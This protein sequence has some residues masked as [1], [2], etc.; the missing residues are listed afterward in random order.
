MRRAIA[1]VWSAVRKVSVLVI[2]AKPIVGLTDSA[3]MRHMADSVRERALA[4]SSRRIWSGLVVLVILL[5][6][7][8][9][10]DGGE[11]PLRE[12]VEPVAVPEG[13]Q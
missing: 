6:F 3:S 11:Q 2:A 9:W 4:L 7:L 1:S 10:L 8:A 5:L 12:I 13:L